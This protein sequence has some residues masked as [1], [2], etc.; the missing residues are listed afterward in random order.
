MSYLNQVRLA[1]SGQFQADVSTVNNDVRHFDN[2]SFKEQYQQHQ[3]GAVYNGWWNPVGSG[4]FRLINCSV[5]AA[6]Y[7][8]GSTTD[9]ANVDP[10][11]GLSVLNANDRSSG[12]IVDI[13]PQWQLASQLWGM[14]VRLARVLG[15]TA[16]SFIIG[17]YAENPFRDLWFSRVSGPGG[18][19]AASAVF[20]SVLQGIDWS[21]Q[22]RDSRIL[23]ELRAAADADK[24]S[25]RLVTYAYKDDITKPGFTFGTVSGVIGP[26]LE[27]EPASFVA[28]R[29]FAPQFGSTS[30]NNINFFTGNL[31]AEG[32]LLLDLCNALPIDTHY[33]PLDLGSMTAGTLLAPGTPEGGPLG[34][35]NYQQIGTIPYRDPDWLLKAGGIAAFKLTR[36]QLGNQS[37]GNFNP[38]T[39]AV[40]PPGASTPVVAIR[41]TANGQFVG[42]EPFVLRI[43]SSLS[44]SVSATSTL[45]ATVF[46][47]PATDTVLDAAQSG[48]MPGL[49]GGGG[50][51]QPTASIPVA[52]VPLEALKVP[53]QVTTGNAGTATLTIGAMPPGNPRGYID[54][55]LYTVTYQQ[56]GQN[57]QAFGPFEVISI[58]LR[59]DYPVP[60]VPTWAGNIE[61][62][63][64]QYGNLYPI[65]SRRLVDL[66]N[67][68]SVYLHR[69]ILLLA[70][71]LDIRDPNYMPVTRD[72]SEGKRLTIVKWLEHIGS[73][74]DF[75]AKVQAA[76]LPTAP[77]APAAS[78]APA[79]PPAGGKTTFARSL[80]RSRA[81]NPNR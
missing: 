54:G 13:D 3:E 33:A 39:I 59:D 14:K 23:R 8:D 36:A 27:G 74:A 34:V 12:K 47:Q 52:G 49:G 22:T 7:G 2:V 20:Q 45:Y 60:D 16:T 72:L 67:P 6:W 1:F 77:A 50:I 28:G 17:D 30:W 76:T 53:A 78:V 24:L 69:T 31:T 26:W 29:R 5:R 57:R 43:D 51:D 42:A 64:K 11:I 48:A 38:L 68:A 75:M 80:A 65:M 58:H 63:F 19:P 71:S 35:G 37:D 79:E 18:D 40:V 10:A 61:P 21:T 15:E 56:D 73:D 46:G 44:G 62:I 4:A 32:Y 25:I 70:F 9:D 66:N 55:Q 81:G 41:E